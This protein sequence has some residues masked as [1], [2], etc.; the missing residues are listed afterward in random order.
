METIESVSATEVEMY[1]L[2]VEICRAIG[3][4]RLPA[5]VQEYVDQQLWLFL[6]KLDTQQRKRLMMGLSRQFRRVK[7]PQP[8]YSLFT[9]WIITLLRSSLIDYKLMK[10]PAKELYLTRVEDPNVN[11]ILSRPNIGWRL[12]RF[13]S[14]LKN[15]SSLQGEAND[16]LLNE[17]YPRSENVF[18]C[19]PI[20]MLKRAK[21]VIVDGTHRAVFLAMTGAASLEVYVGISPIVTAVF[22]PVF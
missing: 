8:V 9:S 5:P 2:R 15:Q 3:M 7:L 16:L 4:Q 19:R 17:Y 6:D 11:Q 12:D 14:W 22:P 18:Y 1:Y 10:V 21:V 20:A 13:A